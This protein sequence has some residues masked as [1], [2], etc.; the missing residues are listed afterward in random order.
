MKGLIRKIDPVLWWVLILQ[1]AV[2]LH[3][4]NSLKSDIQVSLKAKTAHYTEIAHK[5][6]ELAELGYLEEKSSSLLQ[7]EARKA[8]FK[9]EAGVAGI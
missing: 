8:G 7:D 4:S 9:V 5:I 6:W 2:F 1:P 3:A